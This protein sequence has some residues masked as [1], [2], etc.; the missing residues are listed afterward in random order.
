MPDPYGGITLP[1][2]ER[3]TQKDGVEGYRSRRWLIARS[4]GFGV[5]L[6]M[7]EPTRLVVKSSDGNQ[8]GILA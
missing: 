8:L 5:T 7:S 2:P 3:A 6:I 1:D 4:T